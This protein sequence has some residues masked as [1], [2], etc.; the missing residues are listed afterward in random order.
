MCYYNYESTIY[1]GYCY[2]CHLGKV[3]IQQ[4]KAIR[5]INGSAYNAI[6]GPIYKALGGITIGLYVST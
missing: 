6:A 1:N 2:G 4:N 5:D 3:K